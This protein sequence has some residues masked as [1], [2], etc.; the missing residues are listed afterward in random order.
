MDKS[1]YPLYDT[2][3]IK[4]NYKTQRHRHQRHLRRRLSTNNGLCSKIF[5]TLFTSPFTER[6]LPKKLVEQK[7][8]L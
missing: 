2:G 1:I 4:R 3:K 8:T 7:K 5:G 6:R